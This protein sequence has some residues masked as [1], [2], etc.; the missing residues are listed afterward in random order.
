MS[1]L[2]WMFIA[3]MAVWAGIG[4]YLLTISVRQRRL[5]KRM[6]DLSTGGSHPVDSR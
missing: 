1:N 4:L 6:E 5:E 3:F 2:T